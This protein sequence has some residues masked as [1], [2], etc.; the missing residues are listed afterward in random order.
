MPDCIF[1][2]G[3]YIVMFLNS[4][5]LHYIEE[6]ID[7]IL[8]INKELNDILRCKVI[9]PIF[10]F[11]VQFSSNLI[12]SSFKIF[13]KLFRPYNRSDIQDDALDIIEL[14]RLD[15]MFFGQITSLL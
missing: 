15:Q 8:M 10:K 11:E 3:Y 7:L 12:S 2:Q 1:R 6:Y 13:I 4:N 14:S 5:F 9:Y